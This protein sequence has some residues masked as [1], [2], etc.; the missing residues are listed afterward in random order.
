MPAIASLDL[1]DFSLAS[2]SD[3]NLAK[4]KIAF[5]TFPY[6]ENTDD[7]VFLG[8]KPKPGPTVIYPPTDPII[9]I[10]PMMIGTLSIEDPY[11]LGP[12]TMPVSQRLA[13]TLHKADFQ[14][15]NAYYESY[16]QDSGEN[17]FIIKN[18]EEPIYI[19]VLETSTSGTVVRVKATT[20]EELDLLQLA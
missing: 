1:S 7:P 2:L 16:Q 19:K 14:A 5:T 17:W 4:S 18:P 9:L 6:P 13:L 3:P 20:Q 11:R 8:I 10:P 12:D 15:I